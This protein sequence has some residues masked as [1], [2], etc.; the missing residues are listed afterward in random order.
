MIKLQNDFFQQWLI[1]D[2]Y[3]YVSDQDQDIIFADEKFLDDILMILDNCKLDEARLTTLISALCIIIYD[4]TYIE[5]DNEEDEGYYNIELKERVI[6]ELNK[7]IGLLKKVNNVGIIMPYIKDVVYPQLRIFKSG[8][9]KNLWK[10]KFRNKNYDINCEVIILDE[11]INYYFKLEIDGVV[12][13]SFDLQVWELNL[14]ESSKSMEEIE[15]KFDIYKDIFLQRFDLEIYI[16]VEVY[17]IVAEKLIKSSLEIIY[18][19]NDIESKF[20]NDFGL[21]SICKKFSLNVEGN[22]IESLPPTEWFDVSLAS[23]CKEIAGKYQMKNC[24]GCAYSDYNPYGGNN[25]GSL[26]C[27]Y[28]NGDKYLKVNC[29]HKEREEDY[30]IFEAFDECGYIQ[31]KET[32]VCD[33]F[34]PRINTLG[35]YR[36]NIY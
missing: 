36:G 35:G 22:Y 12:F 21:I 28:E 20:K 7:R 31:L 4:N 3:Y 16:P 17:D 5:E 33:N 1:D 19:N 30:S 26:F 11:N 23:I 14:E 2:D 15:T 18:C 9:F 29:K 13:Y 8:W 10:A 6:V 27:F 25:I 32:D 34:K 24:F